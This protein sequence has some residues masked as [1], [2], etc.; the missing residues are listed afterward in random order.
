[1]LIFLKILY[2]S[3]QRNTLYS[4]QKLGTT[5]CTSTDEYDSQ[6]RAAH[7]CQMDIESVH[8]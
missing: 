6:T 5:Q 4:S 3:V 1:M 7:N 8:L 2:K